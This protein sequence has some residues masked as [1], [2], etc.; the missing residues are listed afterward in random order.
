MR[1]V[2]CKGKQWQS[3]STSRQP[4]YRKAKHSWEKNDVSGQDI[5]G[6]CINENGGTLYPK[7][8]I[9][10]FKSVVLDGQKWKERPKIPTSKPFLENDTK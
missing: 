9:A 2:K 6:H 4:N 10:A 1:Q 8:K 7:L 5:I 3:N